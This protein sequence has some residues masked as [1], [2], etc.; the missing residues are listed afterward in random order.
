MIDAQNKKIKRLQATIER[1]KSS[2]K[3]PTETLD[4]AFGK[5][6]KQLDDFG[7]AQIKLHGKK[8]KVDDTHLN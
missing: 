4:K 3:N 7:K 1:L 5:V 2:K 6:P 8:K